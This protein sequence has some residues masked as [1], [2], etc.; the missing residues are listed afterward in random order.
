MSF[1]ASIIDPLQRARLRHASRSRLSRTMYRHLTEE[2][3]KRGP[4]SPTSLR[5]IP[6]EVSACPEP[7]TTPHGRH[8]MLGGSDRVLD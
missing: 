5:R 7:C 3:A 8:R 4:S 2:I 6:M 1:V